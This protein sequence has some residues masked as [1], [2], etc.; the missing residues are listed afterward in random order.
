MVYV[1]SNN[2]GH[3]YVY[4]CHY[5]H[6]YVCTCVGYLHELKVKHKSSVKILRIYSRGMEYQTKGSGPRMNEEIFKQIITEKT[7]KEF[8][9][10]SLHD[11]VSKTEFGW[12]IVEMEA[13]FQ[14]M[15]T[16]GQIP[17]LLE[18][19]RYHFLLS[20]GEREVFSRERFDIVLCT[21]NEAA[22]RRVERHVS[23]LQCIVDECGYAVEPDAMIPLQLTQHVVLIGDHKQ[24]QPVIKNR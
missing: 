18:E 5:R 24:L 9:R 17:S 7:P 21:C 10:Y 23:P 16:R 2:A 8:Q 4:Q 3:M 19:K 6:M 20:A 13:S 15:K 14:E 11:K 22:S 12:E 1:T